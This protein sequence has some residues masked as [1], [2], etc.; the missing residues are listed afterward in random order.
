MS[1]ANR[2]VLC[3]HRH[4][5]WLALS[6]MSWPNAPPY[7]HD[8]CALASTRSSPRSS[9]FP[10]VTTS[11]AWLCFPTAPN[12]CA[13]NWPSLPLLGAACRRSWQVTGR[14]QAAKTARKVMLASSTRAASQ[15]TVTATC[16][17]LK[18][19]TTLRKVTLSGAVSTLA[20]NGQQGFGHKYI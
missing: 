2:S 3:V 4:L 18:R 14:R 16:S 9:L 1:G 8:D 13:P 20:G 7:H 17:W 5:K 11:A 15:W 19:S 12:L 10:L 6:F